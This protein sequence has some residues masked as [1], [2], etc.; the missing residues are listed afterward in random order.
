[1][2]KYRISPSPYDRCWIVHRNW[3]DTQDIPNTVLD[4]D[5]ELCSGGLPIT[6]KSTSAQKP[7]S[8][9]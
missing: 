1:M 9:M 8:K 7:G 3:K 4:V 2:F 6:K 5:T